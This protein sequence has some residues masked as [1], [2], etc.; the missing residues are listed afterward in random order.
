[1]NTSGALHDFPSQPITLRSDGLR[2]SGTLHLPETDRPPVVIGCH[3]LMSDSSSPKQSALARQ[4]NY[5]GL[6]YLR[7]DHRGCGAS[8]GVFKEVTSLEARCKDL[9]AAVETVKNR[10]DIGDGLGLFGSS[11]G[12]TVSLAVAAR[13]Q[14]DALVT[15]AAPI[16]SD[17]I[18]Q[19]PTPPKEVIDDLPALD[20]DKMRFDITPLL[21]SIRAIHVFHGSNDEVVPVAHARE[22]FAA[23]GKPKQLTLQSGGDHRVSDREH[24]KAFIQQ[25]ADWF[26]AGLQRKL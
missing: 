12:G 17:F 5:L 14:V 13:L 24:Q 19:T 18:R 22:I 16:R 7:I 9:L 23:A 6:A 10:P 15:L 2:L 26:Q 21:R 1:L 8:E 3:G 4:C 25:A 11:F 20:P